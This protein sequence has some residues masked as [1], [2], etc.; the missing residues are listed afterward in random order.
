MKIQQLLILV[1]VIVFIACSG[2]NNATNLNSSKSNNAELKSES[3]IQMY[4]GK[5]SKQEVT[6]YQ[7]GTHS[8][9]GN[10]LDGN[11]DNFHNITLFA[12]KS[13]SINLD[14]WIG[15][16]VIINGQEI[17]G[18]PVENG[19]KYINVLQVELNKSFKMD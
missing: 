13:D 3:S 19:P 5:V 2:K 12:L 4:N 8:L 14:K 17:E 18:Y 7:Y 10:L 11:P 1:V 16:H 9:I 6:I 15:K